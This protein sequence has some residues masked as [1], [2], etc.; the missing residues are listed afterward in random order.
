[1]EKPVAYRPRHTP[2]I[3]QLPLRGLESC[4]REW[5]PEAGLP[6]FLLHGWMDSGATWQFVVDALLD[7]PLPYRLIAPDWRGFGDSAWC[8]H[9]YWFPD[10]LADL[11]ALLDA[12]A[13]GKDVVLV[14]H[15]MGA[16]SPDSMP[17]FARNACA[18]SPCWKALVCPNIAPK[19]CPSVIAAGST[20]S[21]RRP[22]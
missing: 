15:S 20:S 10:Y 18:R 5:G 13:P 9:G 1:M 4:V 7:H 21:Q 19:K 11:E 14:G 3:R 6:V 17:A 12:L 22:P 2:R 8:T 16:T